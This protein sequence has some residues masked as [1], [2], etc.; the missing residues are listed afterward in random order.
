MFISGGQD[1]VVPPVMSEQLMHKAGECG[2]SIV[3]DPDLAHPF[4]ETDY[5]KH[6]KRMRL[7]K[8]FFLNGEDN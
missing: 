8:T 1:T 5:T 3:I 2:A 6:Q 4:M 7:L